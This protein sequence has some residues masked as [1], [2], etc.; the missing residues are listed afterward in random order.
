MALETPSLSLLK[1]AGWFECFLLKERRESVGRMTALPLHL[2]LDRF[3]NPVGA[4]VGI[5]APFRRARVFPLETGSLRLHFNETGAVSA[6][7][8]GAG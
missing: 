1:K 8:C 5:V 2:C 3:M 6:C 4:R 7:R